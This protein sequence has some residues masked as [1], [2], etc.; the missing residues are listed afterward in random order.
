MS[1]DNI[2]KFNWIGSNHLKLDVNPECKFDTLI[3]KICFWEIEFLGEIK[4]VFFGRHKYTTM[5]VF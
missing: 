4:T 5:D 1:S 3:N 2:I